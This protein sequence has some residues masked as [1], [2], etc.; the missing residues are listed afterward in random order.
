MAGF[1]GQSA[2]VIINNTGSDVDKTPIRGVIRFCSISS[3]KGVVIDG[4]I[5]GLTPGLHGLHIHESGDVSGGCSTVGDHYNPRGSPHGGPDDD[6]NSRHAGDLGNIRSDTTG[7]STFRFINDLLDVGE[8][9]GR[10]V[11]VTSGAD[12]LGK[13]GNE[14]SKIDGNAG[15]RYLVWI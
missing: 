6:V 1:G 11:V 5:D 14:K 7:R 8:I 12:D 10:S 13:G 4:T 2:V 15:E 9:I 3:E